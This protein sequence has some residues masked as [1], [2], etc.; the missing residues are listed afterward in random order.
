MKIEL[1]N[2]KTFEGH[3]GIGLNAD[4]F[5][6]GVK[7][8]HVHDGAYGGCYEYHTHNKEKMTQ[9]EDWVKQ[10]PEKNFGTFKSKYDL[11]ILVDELFTKKEKEKEEKK[12]KQIYIHSFVWGNP[13]ALS[14]K[15]M[16]FK[17]KHPLVPLT[18]TGQKQAVQNLYNKVKAELKKGETIWNTNL[19]DMNLNL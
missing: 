11:D 1:K 12:L 15:T 7:T 16:G 18:L 14:Y 13:N 10:Q 17:S 3:D 6:D 2:I 19:A 9:L 4:I 5:V 8:A